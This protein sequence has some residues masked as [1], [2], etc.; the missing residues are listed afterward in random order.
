MSDKNV[1]DFID[2]MKKKNVPTRN[3]GLYACISSTNGI[4]GLYDFF[5]SKANL[6]TLSVAR[7]GVVG[8]YYGTLFQEETR[9]L[10]NTLNSLYGAAVIF[11]GDAVR[12]KI[13]TPEQIRIGLPQDFGRDR[14]IAWYYFGGFTL[15]WTF[16]S[17]TENHVMYISST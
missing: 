10:S 13:A 14:R 9:N 17:D 16:A 1:R 3:N 5:E 11:G 4:R 7:N 2:D 15:T 8:E 12:E 6:T